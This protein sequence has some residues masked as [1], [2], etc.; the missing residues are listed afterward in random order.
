MF[1]KI[2]IN[3]CKILLHVLKL[4]SISEKREIFFLYLKYSNVFIYL[5]LQ[6]DLFMNTFTMIFYF[7]GLQ[8]YRNNRIC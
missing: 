2:F 3:N 8:T 5:N 4:K 7:K 1:Y 6:I